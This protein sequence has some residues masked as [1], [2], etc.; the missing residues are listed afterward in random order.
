MVLLIRW[1]QRPI[2]RTGSPG[3]PLLRAAP[4][5]TRGIRTVVVALR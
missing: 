5:A 1:D 4:E 2:R 3:Q